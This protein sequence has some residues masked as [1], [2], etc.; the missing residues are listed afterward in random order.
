[1]T[2]AL[3][4][5]PGL[6]QPRRRRQRHHQPGR[7][8]G[9][10]AARRAGGG[11]GGGG[12]HHGGRGPGR[13]RRDRLQRVLRDDGV[14]GCVFVYANEWASFGVVWLV[15]VRMFSAAAATGVLQRYLQR[16]VVL[17]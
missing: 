7:G 11:G 17:L 1:M 9:G 10:A 12:R 13:G 2:P 3:T 8:G 16:W 6:L 4:V 14:R 15:E 5:P